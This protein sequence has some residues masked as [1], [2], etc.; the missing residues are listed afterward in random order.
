MRNLLLSFF[1]LLSFTS[2]AQSDHFAEP[3]IGTYVEYA[4]VVV[5]EDEGSRY[6]GKTFYPCLELDFKHGLRG[7][8]YIGTNFGLRIDNDLQMPVFYLGI[9]L[10]HKFFN[11][12]VQG[13][14]ILPR[15]TMPFDGWKPIGYNAP[16]GFAVRVFKG[17]LRLR[18][19]TLFYKNGFTTRV[20]MFY[21][22][23]VVEKI[24]I[25]KA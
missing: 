18:S 5:S 15:M 13:S 7:I 3:S 4:Q 22:F 9:T 10:R 17:H 2:F 20:G 6:T 8:E 12:F 25:P 24:Q 21:K 11:N 19:E 14:L 1:I 23:N 16:F